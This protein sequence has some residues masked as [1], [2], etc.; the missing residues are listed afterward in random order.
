MHRGGDIGVAGQ[1][2]GALW[3]EKRT[4]SR[5]LGTS[6]VVRAPWRGTG[7]SRRQAGTGINAEWLLRAAQEVQHVVV[8]EASIATLADPIERDL[9][10]VAQA[11]DGVDVQVQ[12][13]RDLGRR[14]QPPDLVADHR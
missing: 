7:P 5:E 8:P 10:A 9:A 11:L 2:T 6:A 13:V 3:H 4:D 12:Q 14:K 1:G